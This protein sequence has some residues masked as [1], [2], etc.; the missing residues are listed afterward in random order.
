MANQ[1]ALYAFSQWVAGCRGNEKQ[2][3]QTFVQKLLTAWGWQDAT[4][5][6]VQFE[7]K[8]PKGGAGGGMGYADALIPGKVLIEMKQR[9]EALGRQGPEAG[10]LG[11]SRRGSDGGSWRAARMLPGFRWGWLMN[12]AINATKIHK[13]TDLHARNRPLCCFIR[14]K[15]AKSRPIVN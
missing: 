15:N 14:E 3:A 7:H 2:E 10:R 1:K 13:R 5:A 8:I 12:Y 4:E 6:G 9:G 11:R